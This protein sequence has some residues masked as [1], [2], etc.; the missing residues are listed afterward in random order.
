MQDV[1]VIEDPSAAAASLDPLRARLLR[2]LAAPSSA[3]ALAAKVG[4]PRQKVNYHL[5]ALEDHGLVA[6]LEER[7]KGN[8]MERVLQATAASYIISPAALAVVEPDPERL[9]DR[10][11]AY[12]LLALAARTVRE[13]GRLLA[14]AVAAGRQ[15]ATFA[16]DGE[17]T[18]ASAA[19]RAA[20]ATELGAEVA[21]LA[22]KYHDPSATGGRRHRLV[23]VLHPALKPDAATGSA[24]DQEVQP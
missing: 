12:W 7:R 19:S 9:R 21:R 16:A 4:L 20:F 24:P 10:F 1:M 11:S 6:L 15:L 23:V 5:R 8:V 14:G 22:A 18:F 3:A 13:V 2:E 17:I